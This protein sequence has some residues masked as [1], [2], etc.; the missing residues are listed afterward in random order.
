[1]FSLFKRSTSKED[2]KSRQDRRLEREREGHRKKHQR[3]HDMI[4]QQ[5]A[6]RE[7]RKAAE[8]AKLRMQQR[9]EQDFDD[10]NQSYHIEHRSFEHLFR[11][12]RLDVSSLGQQ[13]YADWCI[14]HKVKKAPWRQTMVMRVKKVVETAKERD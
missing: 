5:E 6:Q 3:L 2:G 12:I 11:G 4:A 7:K 1:M 14:S 9:Q 10:L 8:A 13:T